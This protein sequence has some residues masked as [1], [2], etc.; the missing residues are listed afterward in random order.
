MLKCRTATSVCV[1][2]LFFSLLTPAISQTLNDSKLHWS[3]VVSG[4]SVPTAMAFI[5]YND[6][7]VLQKNDGRVR[8]VINGVLQ[9]GEVLDL[10]VDTQSERGLLGI[11]LHPN[12][13]SNGFVYL[14]YTQSTTTADTSGSALDNRVVRYTWNGGKLTSPAEIA[15]LPVTPGPNHNGGTITLGPDGKLYIV[16]G[17]LNRTGQLQNFPMGAAPDDSGVILRFNDDGTVPSDNPFF[18]QG[19]NL[20]KYYAYGIRNSFGMA[21]EPVTGE[22]W[23]TENGPNSYDEINQVLPGFN[24]GWAQI[25]GPDSRDPQDESVLFFVLGSHYADPKFSWLTPVGPTALVF[26][27]SPRLGLAY[28]GDLFVGDIVHGRLY[29]F[30]VNESRD[31]FLFTAPGLSDLVADSD[32]ELQKLILGSGFGGITDLK[33]GPDGRLYILSYGQGKIFAISGPEIPADF[34][35]DGASDIAVYETSTGNWF[36]VHSALGF[37]QHLNFGG[38]NFLPVPGDFDGDGVT[39]TAVYDTTN[40]NWFIDQSTAGFRIHPSFGG[41]GY[42]PVPGDYDGDGKTDVAVYE[43]STGHWFFVGSTLGFGNHLAFGGPGFIP[44]PEDYDGDGQTDT[45][46]YDTATGHWFINQS[47]AGFRVHPSFGGPGFLPVPG[48]YDGDGRSDPGVY[49]TSTGNWFFVGSTSGFGQH[50]SFGG[51]GFVPVPADYDG[52]GQTDTAVYEQIT[53]NWF[54]DQTTAGFRVHAS[55]GGP[56][57]VPVLPQVTILRSLGL[58]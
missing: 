6:I 29:R 39:D 23:M 9:A 4:L 43:E 8:R 36:F 18:S 22:L 26:M 49:Q 51:S 16:I 41:P 55:F 15:L 1:L 31:G 42:I 27:N 38:A 2:V 12:F 45:A 48:D 50:L 11:A 47:S 7:L 58:P 14:Y 35:G 46:V 44:V 33:V 10:A 54:I 19:G 24:S 5:G 53:G 21:F 28:E 56:G 30:R 37:G 13:A 52:D 57:F 3:E 34:D 20:A 40:G 32:T 17:D 25:M